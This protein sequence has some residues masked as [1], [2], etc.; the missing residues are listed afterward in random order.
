MSNTQRAS[1]PEFLRAFSFKAPLNRAKKGHPL[2]HVSCF[3]FPTA[4]A[5]PFLGPLLAAHQLY[6]S[7][8]NTRQSNSTP[9]PLRYL[10]VPFFNFTTPLEQQ[11]QG[12]PTPPPLLRLSTSA[13]Y[14]PILDTVP[15]PSRLHPQCLVDVFLQRLAFVPPLFRYNIYIYYIS[16]CVCDVCMFFLEAAGGNPLWKIVSCR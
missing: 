13:F 7:I 1:A 8:C 12:Y 3:L 5:S 10:G 4:V 6:E 14:F 11:G 15:V 2:P 16:F 9:T